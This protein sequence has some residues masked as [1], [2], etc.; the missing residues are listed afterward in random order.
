MEAETGEFGLKKKILKQHKSTTFPA[1]TRRTPHYV[2]EVIRGRRRHSRQMF[3]F[4][5]MKKNQEKGEKN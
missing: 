2:T 4:Y 5:K 3:F 1:T